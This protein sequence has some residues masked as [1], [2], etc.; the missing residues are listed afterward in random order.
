MCVCV[1]VCAC[2]GVY[3][4]CVCVC[5]FFLFDKRNWVQIYRLNLVFRIFLNLAKHQL[6]KTIFLISASLFTNATLCVLVSP[7][8][9]VCVCGCVCMYVCVWVCVC[10]GVRLCVQGRIN[11]LYSFFS[12]SKLKTIQFILFIRQKE[13]VKAKFSKGHT[14]ERGY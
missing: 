11:P 10:V 13:K 1:C 6:A 12:P 3:G 2:V 9:C 8:V 5:L 7:F 14:Q 4:L